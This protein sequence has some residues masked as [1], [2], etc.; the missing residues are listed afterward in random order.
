MTRTH[1]EGGH[2]RLSLALVFSGV[3]G[4]VALFSMTEIN[5]QGPGKPKTSPAAANEPDL[6]KDLDDAIQ[7][8]EKGDFRAFFE[9]YA[10][11]E[12]LRRLRQQDLVDQAAAV[13]SKQ[14]QTSQ[15]LL[16]ILKALRKQT[17]TFDKSRGLATIQFDT[18]ANGVEEVPGELHLPLTEDVKLVGLGGDL[19]KVLAEASKLLAAGEIQTFVERIFPASELARLQQPGALQDLVTQIKGAT[20]TTKPPFAA[21]AFPGQPQGQEIP[22]LLQ[23]LQADFQQLQNL[24]PTTE[25]KDKVQVAIFRIESPDLPARVVKFQKVGADWRMFDDVGRVTAELSRQSKLKPRSAVTTV[26]MERIG[27]NWRFV[28]LPALRPS[29]R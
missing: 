29:G 21:P 14:P 12:V 2:A 26:Q 15:Q 11:V 1:N 20:D 7:I 23:T 19:K 3:L 9:R 17:P 27:G 4:I 6:G 22:N 5:G 13:M 25:Q 10:P 16:A 8:L 28:E 18:A 24:K